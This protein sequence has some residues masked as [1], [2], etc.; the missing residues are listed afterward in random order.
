MK[1]RSSQ[2]WTVK[3][4]RVILSGYD[5]PSTE[6]KTVLHRCSK[7]VKVMATRSK[8]ARSLTCELNLTRVQLVGLI[9]GLFDQITDSTS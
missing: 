2:P 1:E 5:Q 6:P 3:S 8:V 9:V 7:P 4:W